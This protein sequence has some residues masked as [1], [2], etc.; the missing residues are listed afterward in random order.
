M[1]NSCHR[2]KNQVVE[3]SGGGRLKCWTNNN[4]TDNTN[5]PCLTFVN[6]LLDIHL[7]YS[8]AQQRAGERV[9]WAAEERGTCW[10]D[11]TVIRVDRRADR[12]LP[13]SHPHWQMW[14]RRG[15]AV[16]CVYLSLRCHWPS[17]LWPAAASAGTRSRHLWRPG[18]AAARRFPPVEEGTERVCELFQ[19][20]GCVAVK[21]LNSRRLDVQC[22]F[23]VG[24]KKNVGWWV[25]TE[26]HQSL[27]HFSLFL[28]GQQY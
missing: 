3:V 6:E 22:L 13:R 23:F 5:R 18:A 8:R 25:G 2:Q 21:S 16:S 28:Q 26:S 24:N 7:L 14:M 10:L 1:S 20:S 27:S 12:W 11:V 9:K 19:V 4:Y 17:R 15:R